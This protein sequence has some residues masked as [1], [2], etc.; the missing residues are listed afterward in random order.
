[1]DRTAVFEQ[2]DKSSVVQGAYAQEQLSAGYV[3]EASEC[4]GLRERERE[5]DSK[6]LSLS[7]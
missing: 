1:M 5:R 3:F 4:F 6:V 2:E 7:N